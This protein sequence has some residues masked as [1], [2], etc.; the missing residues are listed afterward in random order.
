MIGILQKIFFYL[1]L[2]I[3]WEL[4][5]K[6]SVDIFKIWKPYIFPSPFDVF[7]TLINLV[8]DNTLF[9][10]IG[11]SMKRLVMGYSLSLFIGLSIGLA[12]VKYKYIDK[13]CSPLILG[14]QTLP[15]ICWLPFAILWYG[16]NENA[17]IFVIAIGSTFAIAIATESGIK[18][19]SPLYIKAGRNMGASGAALYWNIIIPASL[20]AI[21]SGMKQGWSFA[22]RGLMAGEMLA[23]SKG[24]GQVLM[25]GR[26]L[27]DISQVVAVML[28]IILLGL[29]IDKL[30][31]SKIET[32]IRQKWGLQR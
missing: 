29:S 17:I 30:V 12:L 25:T 9:I 16:L 27:A 21:I 1:I 4:I 26:E 18:N 13:N 2:I 7:K 24:L 22:W 5:Y 8:E 19:V 20:P 3:I 23:A 14:L 10:A 15:S 31:F 6:F 32:D 11:V 28:I